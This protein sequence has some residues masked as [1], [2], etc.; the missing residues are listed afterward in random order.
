MVANAVKELQS[1]KKQLI[2]QINGLQKEIG[3]IDSAIA[4]LSGITGDSEA[5]AAPVVVSKGKRTMSAA[6]RKAI[7][8]AVKAHWAKAKAAKAPAAVVVV[9]QPAKKKFVMS[10][11]HRQALIKAQQAR[12]AKVKAAK[13]PTAVVAKP[14]KKKYK[15]SA[16]A[17]AKL[18]A[19]QKARWAKI[20]AKKK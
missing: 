11:A 2:A 13:T 3:K 14:A 15:M 16:A 10:P 5:V 4:T 7:S 6:A 20:N 17:K 8:E 12:W 1:A 9:A 19:F 18:S